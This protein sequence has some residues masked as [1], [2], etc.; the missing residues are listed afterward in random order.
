MKAYRQVTGKRYTNIE[1][2]G[3]IHAII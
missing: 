2:I 3:S 1:G